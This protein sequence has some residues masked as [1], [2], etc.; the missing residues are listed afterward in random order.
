MTKKFTVILILLSILFLQNSFLYSQDSDRVFLPKNTMLKKGNWALTYELGRMFGYGTDNFEAYTFT[1]KKHLSDNLAIRLTVGSTLTFS[2]GDSKY[3][4]YYNYFDSIR[5]FST[6][7]KYLDFQTS[8][9]F[10]YYFNP[11]SK[12][13]LFI[14]LGPYAEYNYTK[15]TDNDTYINEQWAIG[16]F[17]SLGSEIFLFENVSVIGEYVLKG[18]YGKSMN[19]YI[20]YHY[21]NY[22]YESVYKLNFNTA[23]LGFSFYF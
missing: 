7:S 14:S 8:L 16:L 12:I 4:D 15:H 5:H 3:T 19:K 22:S 13:K 2:N 21:E 18:T 23:R 10:Q 11:A 9:N 17:G 6:K 20:D 1:G